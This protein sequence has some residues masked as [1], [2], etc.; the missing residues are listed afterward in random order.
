MRVLLTACLLHDI[1][2]PSQEAGCAES[3][4]HAGAERARE[5]LADEPAEF[6]EAVCGA[7]ASHSV[8]PADSLQPQTLEAKLLFDADKLDYSGAIGIA[9]VFAYGGY[10]GFPLWKSSDLD[11]RTCYKDFHKILRV[12]DLMYTRAAKKIAEEHHA[13][14]EQFF[15][16]MNSE[17]EGK[18]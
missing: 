14:A 12:R 6:V 13:I 9:R 7:I 1:E 17:V 4:A 5:I 11:E 16:R 3:H 10:R 18:K 15:D 2:R 8:K